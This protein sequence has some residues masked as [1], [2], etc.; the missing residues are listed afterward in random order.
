MYQRSD[1][2]PTETRLI[3]ANGL[4]FE[5]DTC[6]DGARL[7]LCLHGFP[8]FAFSWRYQL[9]LLARLGY[10][11]WAPNLRGYGRTTR[12]RHLADYAME[13]L[14]A[15]VAGLI[16]QARAR[17]VVLIG[18]D[19]GGAIAWT[20]AIQHAPSLERLVDHTQQRSS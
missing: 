1:D 11:A 5:V 7:V 4:T 12:P 3:D 20:Y 2:P 10:R 6:G 13:H 16:G 18:H 15:D 19:W 8:E 9:P 17:S 14:V